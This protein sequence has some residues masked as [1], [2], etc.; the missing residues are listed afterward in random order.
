MRPGWTGGFI[1]VGSWAGAGHGR[2]IRI[3][4]AGSFAGAG[5]PLVRADAGGPG[6]GGG[7]GG[8]YR[9]GGRYP[10][11]GAALA[12]YA[13]GRR[14]GF[15]LLSQREPQQAVDRGGFLAARGRGTGAP[16][17]DAL[18]C[19]GRELQSGQ[20]GALWLVVRR[21]G[22]LEP[23]SGV[24]LDHGFRATRALC[25]ARGLRLPDPG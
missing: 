24:L 7:Q 12:Q 14:A 22:A 23:A 17:G 19:T 15:R 18:R 2:A 13:V 11:L 3:A 10:G 25:A 5:R 21:P 4:G 9:R 16:D 8:T 20:S 1:D 6:G